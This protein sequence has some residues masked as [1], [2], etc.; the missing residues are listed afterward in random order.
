MSNDVQIPMVDRVRSLER[1]EAQVL[2]GR[3]KGL[4]HG[5]IAAKYGKNSDTWSRNL[6]T[7]VFKKVGA[8]PTDSKSEKNEFLRT[9]VCRV[10]DEILEGNET[11][12]ERWP[13]YGWVVV[14]RDGDNVEYREREAHERISPVVEEDGETLG[15]SDLP[16]DDD[17]DELKP[18]G[19]DTTEFV[20]NPEE[21]IT[22]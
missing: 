1:S 19:W 5:Q 7:S 20:E 2:Y 21:E 4:T 6:M 18:L 11:N 17:A 16:L 3:C 8:K 10:L 14:A 9:Y 13:L 22:P 15:E 12:L